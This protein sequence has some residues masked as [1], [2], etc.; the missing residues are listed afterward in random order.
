[1]INRLY[2]DGFENKIDKEEFV[3]NMQHATCISDI[4]NIMIQGDVIHTSKLFDNKKVEVYLEK[5]SDRP[6]C[7]NDTEIDEFMQQH[8]IILNHLDQILRPDKF[9]QNPIMKGPDQER[10]NPTF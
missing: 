8:Q 6:T 10:Y 7:K 4:S 2:G 5:C 3:Q 9:G 1:M